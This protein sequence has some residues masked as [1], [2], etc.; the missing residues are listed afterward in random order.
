MILYNTCKQYH[1]VSEHRCLN[2]ASY[3][4]AL[5]FSTTQTIATDF[6]LRSHPSLPWT[7]QDE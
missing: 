7:C 6:S 3:L 1:S 2:S 5:P 4:L